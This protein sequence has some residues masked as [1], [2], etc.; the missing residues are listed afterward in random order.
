MKDM[1]DSFNC[2]SAYAIFEESVFYRNKLEFSEQEKKQ[3]P[4]PP[5]LFP[6]WK[7]TQFLSLCLNTS[8]DS[9]LP[10]SA[11][12]LP[13]SR[14]PHFS[15]LSFSHARDNLD[16]YLWFLVVTCKLIE[17]Q[18]ETMLCI[19]TSAD[20]TIERVCRFVHIDKQ[21]QLSSVVYIHIQ[22]HLT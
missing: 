14:F 9:A 3:Q 4:H 1:S 13:P 18:T 2:S 7:T 21:I 6:F 12:R 16:T 19:H 10:C 22:C 8:I 17:L 20:P 5:L 11:H 15:Q